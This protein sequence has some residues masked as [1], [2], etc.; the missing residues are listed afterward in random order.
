MYIYVYVRYI[1]TITYWRTHEQIYIIVYIY[2][3]MHAQTPTHTEIWK[4]SFGLTNKIQDSRTSFINLRAE[5]SR[6]RSMFVHILSSGPTNLIIYS[7]LHLHTKNLKI[8]LETHEHDFLFVE[9]VFVGSQ[10]ERGN[11]EIWFTSI[12]HVT[13]LTQDPRT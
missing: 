4:Q 9:I 1:D 13:P 2:T 11:P 6:T 10:V 12:S 3:Y 5:D 8:E 7:P